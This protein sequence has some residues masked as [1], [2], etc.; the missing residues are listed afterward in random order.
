MP[1][2]APPP[3]PPVEWTTQGLHLPPSDR[4]LDA[5]ASLLLDL[6]E[7]DNTSRTEAGEGPHGIV[8]PGVPE[9]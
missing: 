8:G 7:L 5:L 6:E 2:K 4:A 1:R 3:S 9:L